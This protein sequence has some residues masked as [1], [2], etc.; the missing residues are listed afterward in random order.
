[1]TSERNELRGPSPEQLAAYTDGELHG[2]E[3]EQVQAWLVE[4][5]DFAAEVEGSRRLMRLWE[6]TPPP[7]PSP[8]A[9]ETTLARIE[10]NLSPR[11]RP[12]PPS[13]W[14]GRTG[15]AFIAA[16]VL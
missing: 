2:S 7:A 16:A 9:W 15:L 3:R 14:W 12:N 11:P 5:P 1:M 8:T 13:S 6:A 10:A 4:H